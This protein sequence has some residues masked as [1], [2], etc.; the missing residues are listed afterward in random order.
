MIPDSAI[1]ELAEDLVGTARS[2]RDGMRACN[3][4]DENEEDIAV[5]IEEVGEIFLCDQCG[6]WCSMDELNNLGEEQLCDDCHSEGSG[7][8]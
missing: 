3:L 2:L 7:T 4:E 8:C 5:K 6:W 1:K